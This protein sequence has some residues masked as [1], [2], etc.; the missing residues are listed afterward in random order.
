MLQ[1]AQ[2]AFRALTLM[3]VA[4]LLT[5]MDW[6]MVAND[7]SQAAG[8]ARRYGMK[9]VAVLICELEQLVRRSVASEQ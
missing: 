3:G 9:R 7:I 5:G 8:N 2:L 1:A 4:E 6:I